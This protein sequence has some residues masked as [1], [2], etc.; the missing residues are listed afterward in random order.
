[1]ILV[2]RCKGLPGETIKL[3]DD[4]LLVNDEP[5]SEPATVSYQYQGGRND[6]AL[7]VFIFNLYN[8]RMVL[9]SQ[10]MHSTY[11]LHPTEAEQ[12]KNQLGDGHIRGETL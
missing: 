12:I 10:K 1:M 8:Q 7:E 9:N 2:K 5:M 6:S 11:E 4:Q 3:K